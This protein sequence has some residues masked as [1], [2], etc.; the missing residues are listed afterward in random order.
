MADCEQFF[1]KSSDFSLPVGKMYFQNPMASATFLIRQM[2]VIFT[3][4]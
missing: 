2:H 4:G 1:A 3:D